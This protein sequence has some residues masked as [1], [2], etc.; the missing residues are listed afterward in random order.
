MTETRYMIFKQ[1][2][3]KHTNGRPPPSPSTAAVFQQQ[4]HPVLDEK[5]P[6]RCACTHWLQHSAHCSRNLHLLLEHTHSAKQ[7]H[8]G[9]GQPAMALHQLLQQQPRLQ[10]LLHSQHAAWCL[11]GVPDC[12]RPSSSTS[13]L[14]LPITTTG[15]GCCCSTMPPVWAAPGRALHPAATCCCKG[16]LPEPTPAPCS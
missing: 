3:H 1:P 14:H 5:T 2:T 11:A 9:T 16:A 10:L 7:R 12:T 4:S 15:A 8:V 6:H 13:T